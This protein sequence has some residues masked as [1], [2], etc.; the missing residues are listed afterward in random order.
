MI[1]VWWTIR[2]A[3]FI[4]QR[5]TRISR[6]Y[7][8]VYSDEGICAGSHNNSPRQNDSQSS[9]EGHWSSPNQPI[10]PVYISCVNLYGP[11]AFS[12]NLP[13]LASGISAA[14]LRMISSV[15]DISLLRAGV[16]SS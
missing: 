9:T 6:T 15:A 16:P 7:I 4:Q 8:G 5:R 11:A 2:V 14:I 1:S 3:K 10:P 13:R 12:A